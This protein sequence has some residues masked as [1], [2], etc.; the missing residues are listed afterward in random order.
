MIPPPNYVY[1]Q[2]QG[3]SNLPLNRNGYLYPRHCKYDLYL[4]IFQNICVG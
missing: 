2:G 4:I 3:A 1:Q